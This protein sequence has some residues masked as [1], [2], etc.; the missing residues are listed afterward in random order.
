MVAAEIKRET[1]LISK[2]RRDKVQDISA[3]E[4]WSESWV[5]HIL[6]VRTHG[7][8]VEEARHETELR[9]RKQGTLCRDRQGWQKGEG[10]N[11]FGRRAVSKEPARVTTTTV[12]AH[13]FFT[14][15]RR[16]KKKKGE[17]DSAHVQLRAHQEKLQYELS[18]LNSLTA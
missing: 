1:R 14:C 7:R 13:F 17:L 9:E 11:K 18:D 12:V 10:R 16:S 5:S 3:C 15:P 8:C 6:S 4:A 2:L